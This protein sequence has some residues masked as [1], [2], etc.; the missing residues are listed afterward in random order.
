M[1]G[2]TPTRLQRALA[3]LCLTCTVCRRGRAR[4]RG[5]SFWFVRRVETHLC[6]CCRAYE[7]VYGR[8]A[9]EPLP[10]QSR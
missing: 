7:R 1:T 5:F 10:E 9:H 6:P 8:K 4:Q 3:D 2:T